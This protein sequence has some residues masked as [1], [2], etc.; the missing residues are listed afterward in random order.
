[1]LFNLSVPLALLAT[2]AMSAPIDDTAILTSRALE[3]RTDFLIDSNTGTIFAN[4]DAALIAQKNVVLGCFFPS[5]SFTIYFTNLSAC[6][7]TSSKVF[8]PA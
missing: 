3:K 4:P 7:G 6:P 1:M 2:V 5:R 8:P